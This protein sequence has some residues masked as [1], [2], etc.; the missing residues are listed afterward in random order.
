RAKGTSSCPNLLVPETWPHQVS[1]S[2][3]GRSKQP[4]GEIL[5]VNKE[6]RRGAIQMLKNTSLQYGNHTY[7]SYSKRHLVP[8]ESFVLGRWKT[9]QN[10]MEESFTGSSPGSRRM[11]FLEAWRVP[12]SLEKASGNQDATRWL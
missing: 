2:H 7:I 3:A 9:D 5:K 12:T 4:Q 11:S 8:R 6:H 10:I 1:T